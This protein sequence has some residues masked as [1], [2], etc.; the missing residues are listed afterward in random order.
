MAV[1]ALPATPACPLTP[2]QP[3]AST[4]PQGQPADFGGASRSQSSKQLPAEIQC[5]KRQAQKRHGMGKCAEC[6]AQSS[7]VSMYKHSGVSK[8]YQGGLEGLQTVYLFK[9]FAKEMNMRKITVVS[10]T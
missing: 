4:S 3:A 1:S 10:Q 8:G 6:N 2:A 9:Y 7:P 5:S